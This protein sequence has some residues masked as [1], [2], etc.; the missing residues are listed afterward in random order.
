M[1]NE[2]IKKYG[3]WFC[4][5]Q[6]IFE[7]EFEVIEQ[8]AVKV[9]LDFISDKEYGSG[10]GLFRFDIYIEPEVNFGRQTD[11]VYTACAHLSAHIGKKEFDKASEDDKVKLLLNASLTLVK[12]LGQRVPLPKD[13]DADSLFIEYEKFLKSKSLLLDEVQ[14]DNVII[15]PF[16]TIRF[17]FRRT[18]RLKWIKVKFILT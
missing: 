14:T 5:N 15:K 13:F 3:C 9:F 4:I 12:Y 16:D 1:K 18:K 11:S 10:V 17:V 2:T 6:H 7:K 8:K